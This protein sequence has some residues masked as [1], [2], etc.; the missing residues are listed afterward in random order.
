M[1][2]F[3]IVLQFAVTVLD[4]F[5]IWL[6]CSKRNTLAQKKDK[7]VRYMWLTST[8]L[9][10]LAAAIARSAMTW[11]DSQLCTTH[12]ILRWITGGVI[13]NSAH[14]YP[15]RNHASSYLVMNNKP[16]EGGNWCKRNAGRQNIISLSNVYW[17]GWH[18]DNAIGL[19]MGG[20]KFQSCIRHRLSWPRL[21]FPSLFPGKCW[22][23]AFI[24]PQTFPSRSFLSHHLSIILPSDTA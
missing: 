19:Y 21:W 2:I 1:L 9:S 4:E 15:V 5:K 17:T 18:S 24:M 7:Q 8:W 16:L 3:S 10:V 20:A 12:F 13:P 23:S 22:D 11:R 6:N 14:V